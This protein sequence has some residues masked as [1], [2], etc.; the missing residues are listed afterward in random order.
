M[1]FPSLWCKWVERVLSSARS[2]VLVNGSP[3]FEFGCSK[4]IRQ[5]DPLSPFLFLM[6]MEALSSIFY[7]AGMEGWFKGIQLPNNGP[8]I[9]HLFYADDALLLGEWDK[10][11]VLSVARCLRIFYLYSG[12]KINLHKSNLFGMGVE[13]GEINDMA[14]VVGCN[15]DII[16]LT[17]LG[18]MVGANMNR[19]SNWAPIM[20]VFDKRLSVW[21]AKAISI[22]G[23]LP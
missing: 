11:N 17:Y 8:K 15:M 18:I 4:G 16:P 14:K 19:I 20:E 5:G 9:S 10:E 13:A 1:G 7:K 6:V 22:G 2:S 12:L 21:K 23:D 3:T